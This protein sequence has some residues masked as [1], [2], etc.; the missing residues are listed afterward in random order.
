MEKNEE[1]E[2]VQREVR[3][4]FDTPVLEVSRMDIRLFAMAKEA[5]HA[6][7]KV[8]EIILIFVDGGQGLHSSRHKSISAL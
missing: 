6:L 1:G 4:Q 3:A 2:L 7:D 5:I 8:W